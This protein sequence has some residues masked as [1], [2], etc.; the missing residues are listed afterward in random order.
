MG[1]HEERASPDASAASPAVA[2]DLEHLQRYTLGNRSLQEEVLA[3]F[4]SQSE[5]YLQQL[6]DASDEKAWTDTAHTLKGSARSVG[7]MDVARGAE[8]AERLHGK[9]QSEAHRDALRE[10]ETLVGR[11]NRCIGDILGKQAPDV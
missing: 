6:R 5:V 11:A 10:L 4:R 9:P 7:A 8:D 1:F 3:L 2:I